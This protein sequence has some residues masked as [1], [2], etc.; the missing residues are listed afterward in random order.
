MKRWASVLTALLLPPLV[1]LHASESPYA[2]PAPGDLRCEGQTNP[3]GIDAMPPA[4]SWKL[5]DTR[6]GAAQSAFQILAASRPEFLEE[7]KADVWNSGKVESAQSHLV[8]FDKSIQSAQRVHWKVRYWDLAGNSSPWSAPAWFEMALL[9][10]EDWQARWIESAPATTN[11]AS[12]ERWADFLLTRSAPAMPELETAY[13]DL[14][15]ELP[16]PVVLGKDLTLAARPERARVYAS[17]RGLYRIF[18]NGQRVGDAEYEPAFIAANNP[19]PFYA[20]HDVTDL[21]RAGENRIRC[22]LRKRPHHHP[23]SGVGYSLKKPPHLLLQLNATVDGRN[24]ILAKTDA[25]WQQTASSILKS[26]FYIGEVLDA[27]LR[28]ASTAD[29]R[30]AGPEW[31]PVAE[32]AQPVRV[33]C[34]FFEP[35]RVIREVEPAAVFSP[36]PGVWTFDLGEMITGT[37]EWKVPADLPAG[38]AIAFRYSTE[39]RRVGS[40]MPGL[41]LY[42]PEA[43]KFDD[44]SG[45]LSCFT[46]LGILCAIPEVKAVDPR[47]R[48]IK[49]FS[50]VPC[51]LYV[52]GSRNG[53]VWRSTERIHAFRYVEVVGLKGQPRLD[54]L[55]AR[56]IHT[57]SRRVGS[58]ECSEVAFN[59]FHDVCV[60]TELMN[61]HGFF[62]DCWDREKWPWNGNWPKERF[63]L[64][65]YDNSR[66]NRKVTLD[67]ANGVRVIGR[68]GLWQLGG[69]NSVIYS[70]TLI[71]L[72]WAAYQFSGDIRPL[73]EN[74]DAFVRH[75]R[76]V[77]R[78]FQ[79]GNSLILRNDVIGDWLWIGNYRAGTWLEKHPGVKESW[80]DQA[81]FAAAFPRSQR[82][83]MATAIH[84][85]MTGICAKIAGILGRKEDHAWLQ[86]LHTHTKD[87]I[88]RDFFDQEE[89]T[90][91]RHPDSG[92][93]GTDV[94]DALALDT[95]VVPG[96]VKDKVHAQLLDNLRRRNHAPITGIIASQPL[97]SVLATFGD[98]DDAYAVMAREDTPGIKSL[99]SA[100][101]DGLGEYFYGI[102]ADPRSVGSRCHADM[103]GWAYWFYHGLGGLRPDWRHPGFKHFVLAPQIPRQMGSARIVH[104]SPYGKIVSAWKRDGAQ[105]RWEVVVPPNST[106]SAV[107]PV[108][109]EKDIREAGKPLGDAGLSAKSGENG[110]VTVDLA[111]GSY[112]FEFETSMK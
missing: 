109:E 41:E 48:A 5:G 85:D 28:D 96:D 93:W 72:P 44:R 67:N 110:A 92:P 103:A 6:R 61:S 82:S 50:M 43:G 31:K 40:H 32:S 101:P 23:N 107:F 89:S 26:H 68:A 34:R 17:A 36:A 3:L 104:E 98:A 21:L 46:D 15:R 91:G 19:A 16:G 37:V 81:M 7:G 71:Y 56:M 27:R 1:A 105:V 25:T 88:H 12:T 35:E 59:R 64:Y 90:Y 2:L 84:C 112:A 52:I 108:A 29:E 77:Y 30:V 66:L 33:R 11:N 20:T 99:L 74:F 111:A 47:Y 65:A 62:A 49:G 4:L 75:I 94:E 22:V 55:K 54:A 97:L 80:A 86:D 42:Y 53:A 73:R 83:F 51:D 45:L 24:E 18:L 39:L 100:S 106:A 14:L 57:D 70:G 63:M 76:T 102:S 13:R 60:K 58:F 9:T 8:P 69:G 79:K 95:G 87:A 78:D 10:P 38:S